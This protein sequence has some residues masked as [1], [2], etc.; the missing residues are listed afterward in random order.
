MLCIV[1]SGAALAELLD[2][3]K[4]ANAFPVCAPALAPGKA[5]DFMGIISR[6]RCVAVV[7]LLGASF[8]PAASA[9]SHNIGVAQVCGGFEP[10]Q[11]A[12][13]DPPSN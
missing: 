1:E 7:G 6:T 11:A 2:A 10:S 9:G 5:G 8:L 13:T 12:G 4:T 3:Q